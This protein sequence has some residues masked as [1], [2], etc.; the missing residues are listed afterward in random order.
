MATTCSIQ[1][2]RAFALDIET[3]RC[4]ATIDNNVW[5][6]RAA[7]GWSAMRGDLY[8]VLGVGREASEAVI[9]AAYRRLARHW[10]RYVNHGRG[11][12]TV[13]WLHTHW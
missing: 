2:A 1:P 13:F 7:D 11:A 6:A 9:K 10:R 5:C 4:I 3:E 12:A 8:A